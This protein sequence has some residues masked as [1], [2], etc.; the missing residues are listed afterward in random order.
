LA[1]VFCHHRYGERWDGGRVFEDGAEYERLRDESNARLDH[2]ADLE[3][4]LSFAGADGGTAD[5]MYD[6]IKR[7]HAELE[8]AKATQLEDAQEIIGLENSLDLAKRSADEYHV[9]VQQLQSGVVAAAQRAELAERK[10]AVA[11]T[12]LRV[13]ADEYNWKH[14]RQSGMSDWYEWDEDEPPLEFAART[15]AEIEVLK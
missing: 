12:T 10:L 6:E 5:R 11:T 4:R 15:L 3:H 13:Y 14:Q 2:I 8:A 9:L 1:V 7:L